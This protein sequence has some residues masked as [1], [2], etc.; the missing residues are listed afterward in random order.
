MCVRG[1]GFYFVS[2]SLLIGVSV[3]VETKRAPLVETFAVD[4]AFQYEVT[5]LWHS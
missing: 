3:F 4:H 1:S 5:A 2:S